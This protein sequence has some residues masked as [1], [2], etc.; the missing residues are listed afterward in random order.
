M[1]E[2]HPRK[3]LGPRLEKDIRVYR[4]VWGGGAVGGGEYAA[5]ANIWHYYSGADELIFNP[6]VMRVGSNHGIG[7]SENELGACQ[8]PPWRL[9]AARAT[10]KRVAFS[11]VPSPVARS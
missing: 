5:R 10:M 4:E 11:T 7:L 2:G 3:D 6:A 1:A 9:A 8:L